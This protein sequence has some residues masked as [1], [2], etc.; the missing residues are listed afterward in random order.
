[1]AKASHLTTGNG[2]YIIHSNG[3]ITMP[4]PVGPGKSEMQQHQKLQVP[5]IQRYLNFHAVLKSA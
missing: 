2:V 4:T 1:M 3:T 5:H